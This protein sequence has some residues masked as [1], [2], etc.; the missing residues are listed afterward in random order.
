MSWSLWTS[1]LLSVGTNLIIPWLVVSPRN[2]V[3]LFVMAEEFVLLN[4]L[5]ASSPWCRKSAR[6]AADTPYLI[7]AAAQRV[8][9]QSIVGVIDARNAVFWVAMKWSP[10]TVPKSLVW[11]LWP[12]RA[13]WKLWAQE[14]S[15]WILWIEGTMKGLTYLLSI[16]TEASDCRRWFWKMLDHS[17]TSAN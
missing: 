13:G 15:S 11:I 7:E 1:M 3:C 2:V 17:R 14:K 16:R 9:N 10:A 8:G 12:W 4:N 6:G 5:V